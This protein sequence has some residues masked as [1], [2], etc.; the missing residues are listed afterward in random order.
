MNIE[1]CVLSTKWVPSTNY[2]TYTFHS[3][4]SV[5]SLHTTYT[6]NEINKDEIIIGIGNANCFNI[7][8]KSIQLIISDDP[9]IKSH[10]KANCLSSY[11]HFILENL[12]FKQCFFVHWPCRQR[13]IK[14][15]VQY[16]VSVIRSKVLK[17][18]IPFESFSWHLRLIS[19]FRLFFVFYLLLLLLFFF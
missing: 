14:W 5:S 12:K 19:L 7:K 18:R 3:L 15:I 11:K 17:Q 1:Y 6:L 16:L 8:S 9:K 2:E 4:L 13:F 10:T